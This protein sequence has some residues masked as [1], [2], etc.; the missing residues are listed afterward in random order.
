MI[1]GMR[2]RGLFSIL[3]ILSITLYFGACGSADASN[4][5]GDGADQAATASADG[6]EVYQKYC[7][8]CHGSDG[9]LAING[10]K[11]ITIS[12]LTR[13]ER[14]TL[15]REG[16]GLMTPF[17]GILSQDEIEAVVSYSMT[18]K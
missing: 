12:Q 7:V 11:D 18:L 3:I 5:S 6:E 17:E 14:I 4:N 16:K 1:T 9:K 8:L 13:E 2:I 15:I 10:A